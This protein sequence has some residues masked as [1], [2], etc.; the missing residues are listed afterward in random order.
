VGNSRGVATRRLHGEHEGCNLGSTASRSFAA[1]RWRRGEQDFPATRWRRSEQEH[2]LGGAEIR[3]F[4]D[5]QRRAGASASRQRRGE[6][7]GGDLGGVTS[8][9]FA[10]SRRRR[11]TRRCVA[12]LRRPDGHLDT[13]GIPAMASAEKKVARGW[14]WKME[15]NFQ[16]SSMSNE[17][18]SDGG[19]AYCFILNYMASIVDGDFFSKITVCSRLR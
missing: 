14:S 15:D 1:C 19:L 8:R 11:G 2:N 6:R 7:E 17:N 4:S 13:A 18:V 12:F 10:A 3:N 9:S 5:S 16:G